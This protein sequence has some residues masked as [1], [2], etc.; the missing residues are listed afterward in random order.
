MMVGCA[1]NR[2]EFAARNDAS[3]IHIS[4]MSSLMPFSVSLSMGDVTM[5]D[6]SIQAGVSCVSDLDSELAV[7]RWCDFTSFTRVFDRWAT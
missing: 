1:T 6:A 4:S 3:S 2:H 5:A 7:T